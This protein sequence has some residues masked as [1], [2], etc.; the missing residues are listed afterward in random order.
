MT[1]WRVITVCRDKA[2]QASADLRTLLMQEMIGRG[3]L[4]Q[5]V[6]IACYAHTDDDIGHVLTAFDASCSVYAHALDHGTADVLVGPATRPVFRKWNGC[7]QSCPPRL[8][9]V[10]CPHEASCKADRAP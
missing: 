4:F 7:R 8:E 6:Y 1:P 2:G 3:V 10:A 5:G 9:G